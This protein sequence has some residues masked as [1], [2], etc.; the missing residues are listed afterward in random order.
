MSIIQPLI[1]SL[2]TEDFVFIQTH[3]FPDHDAV[4]SAFALQRL[5]EN[6]GIIGKIIYEGDL[7]RDS[8]AKMILIRQSSV[9]DYSSFVE[10]E[11]LRQ[12]FGDVHE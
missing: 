2:K 12:L 5:F 11:N 6:F 7:Q 8:L 9:L 10:D 3:N 1:N 4:A